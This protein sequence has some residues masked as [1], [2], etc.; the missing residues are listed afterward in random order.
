VVDERE[1]FYGHRNADVGLAKHL[2]E[3]V[4]REACQLALDEVR[5]VLHH[6][7]ELAVPEPG[8]ASQ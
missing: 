4:E 3:G 6:D 2:L 8:G 1:W 5:A 7:P